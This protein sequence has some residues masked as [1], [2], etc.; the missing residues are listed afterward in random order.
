[1]KLKDLMETY[2]EY[3]VLDNGK[4]AM[5]AVTKDVRGFTDVLY[6]K[7]PKPKTVWDLKNDDEYYYINADGYVDFSTYG[8]IESEENKVRVG[9]VFLTKEEAEKDVERRKVETLLLKH[10]GHRWFK[11]DNPNY[12]LW[13]S[14]TGYCL[15]L[16]MSFVKTQGV[17]YFDSREE[18]TEAI[19][20]IGTE[21]IRKALFEVR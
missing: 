4:P 5:T 20:Q 14:D 13:N 11:K 17:I 6:L 1:M 10:G 9:N 3:E 15:N 7:K 19:E 2:G 16:G 21:R 18:M 12:Y 8:E